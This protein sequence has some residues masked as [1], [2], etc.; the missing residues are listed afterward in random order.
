[1]ITERDTDLMQV[2]L[3][4]Y[5]ENL[6]KEFMAGYLG[7]RGDEG[8]LGEIQNGILYDQE[9]R[10]PAEDSEGQRDSLRL[11]PGGE[12]RGADPFGGGGTPIT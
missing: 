3:D 7:D 1:M 12:P 8:S 6:L 11:A 5:L 9:G 4:A 10:Q 2:E